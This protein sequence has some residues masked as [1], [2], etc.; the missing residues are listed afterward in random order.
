MNKK[1]TFP[2]LAEL[3]SAATNT[4]K[5]MSELALR[6]MF[7]LISS[8]LVDGESVKID[9]LGVF[10]VTEVSPRRSVNVN[11]GETIEIPG[12]GKISFVPDKRLAEAVN[13]PFASFESVVLDDDVTAE[14]LTAIDSTVE[15]RGEEPTAEA[16][17]EKPAAEEPTAEEPV[18]EE[19]TAEEPAAEEPAAEAEEAPAAEESAE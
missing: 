18:A 8:K 19:P 12:H 1:L 16:P 17:A 13:A 10:K 9:G 7:A 2:E 15:D 3:L 11:T 6:E 4:S 14:M 5:R